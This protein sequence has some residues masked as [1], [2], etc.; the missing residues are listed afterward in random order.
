MRSP[1]SRDRH[2]LNCCA[3]TF[4][5]RS[6]NP[7]GFRPDRAH[8]PSHSL[9]WHDSR[10][11]AS[12]FWGICWIVHPQASSSTTIPFLPT[13]LAK[14]ALDD[15]ACCWIVLIQ[16]GCLRP[17]TE[18]AISQCSPVSSSPGGYNFASTLSICNQQPSTWQGGKEKHVRVQQKLGCRL[19]T[20]GVSK[21]SPNPARVGTIG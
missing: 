9:L 14:D 18:T 11:M 5:P 20:L 8:T 21:V 13:S 16:L 2:F 3:E 15:H 17:A 12:G 19:R 1:I 6:L 7:R 10:I 4:R